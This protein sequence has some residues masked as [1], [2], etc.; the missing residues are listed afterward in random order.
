MK[1]LTIYRERSRRSESAQSR[2]VDF[3]LKK[4]TYEQ[5]YGREDEGE[6]GGHD[7]QVDGMADEHECEQVSYTSAHR[8][9][10]DPWTD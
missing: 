7:E 8:N 3:D 10:R 4:A 9:Q 5:V 6:G 1:V 2:Q